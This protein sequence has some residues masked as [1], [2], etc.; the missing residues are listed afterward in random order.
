MGSQL[1]S[2]LAYLPN[3]FLYQSQYLGNLDNFE[4][5]ERFQRTVE[6]FVRIFEKEP[7]S[8]LVD[9]H[10]EYLS[11]IA[12]KE[13]A[14]RIGV[15]CFEIQHH[16]AHFASVLAEHQLFDANEKVLGVIWDGTGY[17]NDKQIWGGE[18]FLLEDRRMT[19]WDHFEYFDWIAGDKMARE[20]RL[21]LLSLGDSNMKE[22]IAEKFN[23]EE[24]RIYKTLLG[25]NKLKTSSVGRLFDAAASL[26]GI[27]D[28]NSFEG[29]AAILLENQVGN[30]EFEHCHL[31][32]KNEEDE[33]LSPTKMIRGLFESKQHGVGIRELARDFLFSLASTIKFQAERSG[34][35]KVAFSGGVFQNSIL[36]DMIQHLMKNEFDLYFNVNLAPNDENI[37][38]GQMMYHLNKIDLNR[39]LHT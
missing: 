9:S 15:P 20:A 28:Y 26:L 39:D 33:I 37:A 21:S 8:L 38:H 3:S 24:L 5:Y 1:K 17:G 11:T 35:K 2:T 23:S 4:V 36:I 31:L 12:G 27:C 18:F 13:Y 6:G 30:Y 19:R 29:E 32:W 16:K 22:L 10:P 7:D 34:A 14:A 25:K